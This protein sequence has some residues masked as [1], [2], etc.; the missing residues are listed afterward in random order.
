[1]IDRRVRFGAAFLQALRKSN[2][3]SSSHLR[4]AILRNWPGQGQELH[5]LLA[6][7]S[8][9]VERF[10]RFCASPLMMRC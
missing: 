3:L 9:P 5:R 4:D 1:M 10:Q 2:R 8:T 6:S 7:A